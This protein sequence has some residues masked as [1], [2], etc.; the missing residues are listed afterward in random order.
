MSLARE[1]LEVSKIL[2]SQDHLSTLP[3]FTDKSAAMKPDELKMV[4]AARKAG[5][6]IKYDFIMHYFREM[7]RND[8]ILVINKNLKG[9]DNYIGGNALIE[10]ALAYVLRKKIFLL[11]PLP[12]MKY[13]EEM[14]AMKPVVLCGD[15]KSIK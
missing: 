12:H 4:N 3:P 15:V 13:S 9:I 14:K 8:A 5:K 10:M 11:S 2:E 6:S 1:M 7:K